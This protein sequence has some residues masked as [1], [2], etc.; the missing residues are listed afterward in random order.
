MALFTYSL[1]ILRRGPP[2]GRSAVVASGQSGAFLEIAPGHLEE[3]CEN[4]G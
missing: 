3:A 2:S 1:A 4:W